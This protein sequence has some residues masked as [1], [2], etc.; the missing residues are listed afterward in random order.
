MVLPGLVEFAHLTRLSGGL[1]AVDGFV[2]DWGVHSDDRVATLQDHV[3]AMRKLRI[4]PMSSCSR[5]WQ[6]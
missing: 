3:V 4:I 5:I 1:V 6:W 2:L